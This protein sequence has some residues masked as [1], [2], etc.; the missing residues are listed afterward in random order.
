[1]LTHTQEGRQKCRYAKEEKFAYLK[2]VLHNCIKARIFVA[3]H[4]IKPCGYLIMKVN[5]TEKK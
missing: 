1:M 2:L 5:I 4:R 3:F